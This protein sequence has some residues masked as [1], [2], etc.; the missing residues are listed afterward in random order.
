MDCLLDVIS[1]LQSDV[2]HVAGPSTSKRISVDNEIP[3]DPSTLSTDIEAEHKSHSPTNRVV[4][5]HPKD[6]L[7]SLVHPVFVSWN[8]L[9]TQFKISPLC[10]QDLFAH[11][12]RPNDSR[13]SSSSDESQAISLHWIPLSKLLTNEYL[14]VPID[15]NVVEAFQALDIANNLTREDSMAAAGHFPPLFDEIELRHYGQVRP[16]DVC[17]S[18]SPYEMAMDDNGKECRFVHVDEAVNMSYTHVC[19]VQDGFVMFETFTSRHIDN[20]TNDK[21]KTTTRPTIEATEPWE[22]PPQPRRREYRMNSRV[23]VP[24]SISR[25]SQEFYDQVFD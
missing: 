2:K 7:S 13:S 15:E 3:S 23:R 14:D 12:L 20:G 10:V 5:S 19:T 25:L 16:R 1:R 21:E 4:L 18:L 11:R 8:D 17:R 24:K 6:H 22:Q 9:Q